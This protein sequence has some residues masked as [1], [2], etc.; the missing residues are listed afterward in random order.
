M[1]VCLFVSFRRRDRRRVVEFGKH[2]P[3]H[4]SGAVVCRNRRGDRAVLGSDTGGRPSLP[5]QR[6]GGSP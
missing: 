2:D 1:C 4:Y 3:R 5:E 6:V